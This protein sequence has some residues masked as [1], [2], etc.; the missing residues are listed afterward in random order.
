M[1]KQHSGL[2]TNDSG[3]PDTL[4]NRT[5]RAN[6]SGHGS[7][8]KE[9]RSRGTLSLLYTPKKAELYLCHFGNLPRAYQA[10]MHAGR[11]RWSDCENQAASLVLACQAALV[12][13][14]CVKRV[15]RCA[16][17]AVHSHLR[18]IFVVH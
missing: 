9:F 12:V 2:P 10:V 13:I 16:L 4:V 17:I 11:S 18:T 6:A 8:E 5:P 7:I 15:A 14:E 3:P 1:R